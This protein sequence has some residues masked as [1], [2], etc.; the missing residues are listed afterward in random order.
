MP[1]GKAPPPVVTKTLEE[2]KA[3]AV[4]ASIHPAGAVGSAVAPA[5][6]YV[7]AAQPTAS[8][9]VAQVQAQMAQAQKALPTY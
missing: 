4:P 5:K 9:A 2:A 7:A 6:P 3:A 8:R 1:A